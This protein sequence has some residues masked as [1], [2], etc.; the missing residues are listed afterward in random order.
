LPQTR[1]SVAELNVDGGNVRVQTPEGEP[2][3]WKGYK[4]IVLHEQQV[5]GASFQEN[6]VIVDW[7]N[8]QELAPIVTCLGDGHDGI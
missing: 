8:N 6:Q 4:A 3:I 1:S 7:V 2:S 5:I